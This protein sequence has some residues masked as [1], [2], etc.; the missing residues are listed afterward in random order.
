MGMLNG[1]VA[2][3]TGGTATAY[4]VA[5][6][7]VFGSLATDLNGQMMAFSP[8]TT[9]GATVTLNVDGLGAK[10]LR[11]SPGVELLAGSL[12]QGTP[13]IATYNNAD[14]AWY[15]QGFFGNPLFSTGDVKLTLKTAADPGWVMFNDGTLSDGLSSVGAT[16]RGNVDTQALFALLYNNIS[17]ANAPVFASNGT[18][19]TRAG[20]GTA[21]AA[22]AA[23]ALLQLPK[24]LGRAIAV[25]GSG[26]GLTARTLGQNLG[27]E[28]ATLN[29]ANVP[30]MTV[31]GTAAW[32]IDYATANVPQGT[33]AQI[34]VVTSIGPGNS[35]HVTSN[36]QAPIAGAL[37]V[38][39]TSTPVS[40]MPPESFLNVM[41][42]L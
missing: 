9:N 19:S 2:I 5:S 42:K 22:F 30:A 29:T 11:S 8:H 10:P 35:T 33:G 17:D 18:A 7:Q 36:N 31:G 25:A 13:Y 16:C 34:N 23:H 39:G 28:T 6:N 20:L 4:T 41:A 27:L 3:V 14:G 21:A 26:S 38:G 15:L 40:I 24:T 32:E 1:R 37:T 12:I